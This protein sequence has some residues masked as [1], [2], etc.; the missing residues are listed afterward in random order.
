VGELTAEQKRLA[1]AAT[2]IEGARALGRRAGRGDDA[3]ADAAA[4]AM[5]RAAALA[6]SIVARAGARDERDARDPGVRGG[7]DAVGRTPSASTWIPQRLASIEHADRHAVRRGRKFK[8]PPERL[9]DELAALRAR[10]GDSRRR[11]T[12]GRARRRSR[13][14]RR[15]RPAAQALSE[16]RRGGAERWRRACHERIGRLGMQGGR[17]AI[18]LERGEPAAHGVDRVDVP[19][20][21]PCGRHAA[22]LG[23]VAS[24]GELSRIS[25]AISELAAEANPVATLIFDEADAGVG[26]GVAEVIGD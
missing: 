24:G 1:H 4:Q 3:L 5:L 14:A 9:A 20:R 11:R 6:T 15:L 7:L 16:R 8:L 2:L 18:A 25:L 13:R 23:K 26:G 22:A 17:L 19:R 10:P 21:G 12:S